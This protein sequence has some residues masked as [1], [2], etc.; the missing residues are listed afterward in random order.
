MKYITG[1]YALNLTCSLDTSG[2]WHQSALDW[3]NPDVRESNNSFFYDYGIEE[4]CFVP[5]RKGKI[6]KT[7][8][9]IRAI[10]DLLTDKNFPLLQGMRDCYIDNEKYDNEIFEKIYTMK[11]LPY[12]KEIKEFVGKE[13]MM[14]WI[15]F[16]RNKEIKNNAI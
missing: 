10:L 5:M 11:N 15:I 3:T 16:L 4:N 1:I 12:W 14:K 13:Y 8:N 9:H 6:C 2:D 7:A